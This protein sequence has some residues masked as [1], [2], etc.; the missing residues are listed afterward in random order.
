[1]HQAGSMPEP[2]LTV[3]AEGTTSPRFNA[4]GRS[5]SI[6][7]WRGSGP[8]R[9]HVHYADDEAWHVLEG[10]LHFRFADNEVDVPAGGSVFVPAGVPH[11]YEAISARYL[12]VLSPRLSALIGE[13]QRTPDPETHDAIYRKYE[14][15]L[16]ELA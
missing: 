5:F 16:L 13:L 10:T 4:V 3:P 11:T 2:I 6:H 8:P 1:M 14:S 12:I 9:L 15:E 7:E